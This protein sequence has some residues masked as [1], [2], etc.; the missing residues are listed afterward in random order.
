MVRDL[1][2]LLYDNSLDTVDDGLCR[3]QEEEVIN[4]V[5]KAAWHEL[6]QRLPRGARHQHR[7]YH[8]YTSRP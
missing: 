8:V 4:S 2:L 5:R 1:P 7:A 3:M 6:H